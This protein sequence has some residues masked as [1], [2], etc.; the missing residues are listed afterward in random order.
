MKNWT[1]ID[2]WCD[3]SR[4]TQLG[5]ITIWQHRTLFGAARAVLRLDPSLATRAARAG[6]KSAGYSA[7]KVG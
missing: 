6:A 3:N 2:S 1:K 5:D 7:L 4:A